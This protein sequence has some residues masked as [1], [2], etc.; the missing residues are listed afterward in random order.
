M[1]DAEVEIKIPAG[2]QDGH[3]LRIKMQE[4]TLWASPKVEIS[5]R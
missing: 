3:R 1:K 4:T 5:L 2:V